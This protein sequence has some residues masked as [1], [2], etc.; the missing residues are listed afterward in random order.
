MP[1]PKVTTKPKVNPSDRLYKE[2][3]EAGLPEP[4]KE[5]HFHRTR[6]WRFDLAWPERK[7]ACEVEGA[8]WVGGRHTSGAGY[9][10]DLV[11]YNEA[12]LLGWTVIRVSTTMIRQHEAMHFV[13]RALAVTVIQEGALVQGKLE[14]L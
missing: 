9:S 14:G 12:A 6:G 5:Y 7:L 13:R 2:I 4:T 11:K 10:E 1:Q 8:V 3:L